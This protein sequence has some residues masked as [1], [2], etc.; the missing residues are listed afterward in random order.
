MSALYQLK[1]ITPHGTVYE[2]EVI[3]AFL[4]AE[5][6]FVGVLANHA[7]YITSIPGGRLGIREKDGREKHFQMGAGFFETSRNRAVFLTQTCETKETA[8]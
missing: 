2:G 5:D 1:I 8:T 4:P 6:G 3:H 7:P